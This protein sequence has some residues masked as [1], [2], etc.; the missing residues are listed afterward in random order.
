MRVSSWLRN[1]KKRKYGD[2]KNKICCD[3][4]FCNDIYDSLQFKKAK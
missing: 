2:E 4:I 1:I 3:N